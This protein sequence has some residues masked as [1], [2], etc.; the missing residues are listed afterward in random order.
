VIPEGRR[1][2][3]SINLRRGPGGLVAKEVEDLR[4]RRPF[5]EEVIANGLIVLEEVICGG[6]GRERGR[7]RCSTIRKYLIDARSGECAF[8][9]A[10]CVHLERG[11]YFFWG[12]G[13][14]GEM[15]SHSCTES[16][17]IG[18]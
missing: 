8:K 15:C 16:Y 17:L 2:G 6:E 12:G 5:S 9:Q 3:E 11:G 14:V 4:S 1:R 13:G 7:E 18:I 10:C